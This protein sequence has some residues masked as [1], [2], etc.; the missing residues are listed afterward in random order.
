M[1]FNVVGNWF[2]NPLI[3]L[4]VFWFFRAWRQYFR[5][6]LRTQVSI[7]QASLSSLLMGY[8]FLPRMLI[9]GATGGR[10]NWIILVV[11]FASALLLEVLWRNLDESG[12]NMKAQSDD[13]EQK[14]AIKRLCY[15]TCFLCGA[16]LP[17][18]IATTYGIIASFLSFT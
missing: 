8:L 6:L 4:V 10:A 1:L 5:F 3:L 14:S 17:W 2:W 7:F 15:G 12:Q 13:W 18:S 9:A 11:G 16:C